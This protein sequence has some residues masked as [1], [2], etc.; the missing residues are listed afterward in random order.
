MVALLTF[1]RSHSSSTL[2]TIEWLIKTLETAFYLNLSCIPRA[3][4]EDAVLRRA[5]I[6]F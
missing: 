1:L 3:R 5:L 6:E 4:H 2:R